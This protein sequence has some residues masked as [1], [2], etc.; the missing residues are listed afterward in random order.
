MSSND[1]TRQKLME[2]MRK[3]KAGTSKKT[4]EAESK[5]KAQ[6]KKPV[7]EKEQKTDKANKSHNRDKVTGDSYQTVRRRVWPD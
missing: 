3:T 6:D 1:K 5:V 7:K 4:E 2:S